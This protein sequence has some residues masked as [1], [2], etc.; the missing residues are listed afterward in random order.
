[1]R[2]L[3]AVQGV[4]SI[5]RA[6][7]EADIKRNKLIG[8]VCYAKT[9]RRD[10]ASRAWRQ[11]KLAHPRPRGC[12]SII[13]RQFESRP[14]QADVASTQKPSRSY[15]DA[16]VCR[17][18]PSLWAGARDLVNEH[19]T[20]MTPR[21]PALSACPRRAS[22]TPPRATAARRVSSSAIRPSVRAVQLR[23]G[24]GPPAASSTAS[25]HSRLSGRI[26][27]IGAVSGAG[28]GAATISTRSVLEPFR[29]NKL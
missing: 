22:P 5:L 3:G 28:V 19:S 21:L 27:G 17:R 29:M 25:R 8:L 12:S 6:A 9:L 1:M 18:C 11:R 26:G 7:A 14:A 20:S 10:R 4:A 23:C 24:P 16:L 15:A 2:W 13:F